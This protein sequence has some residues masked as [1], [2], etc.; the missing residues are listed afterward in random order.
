MGRPSHMVKLDAKPLN[1]AGFFVCSVSNEEQRR[2]VL[3]AGLQL[4][5]SASVSLCTRDA[6]LVQLI[7]S[8]R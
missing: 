1:I 5:P 7:T 3:R 8:L 4:Q 6:P 2:I